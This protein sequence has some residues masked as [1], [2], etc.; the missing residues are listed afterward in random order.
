MKRLV[1]A[2]MFATSALL[3]ME[4]PAQLVSIAESFLQAKPILALTDTVVTYPHYKNKS[5]LF[6]QERLAAFAYIIELKNRATS[7]EARKTHASLLLRLH[8]SLDH[9]SP[10][11]PQ[12]SQ[13]DLLVIQAQTLHRIF[14]SKKIDSNNPT[15]T[16][17]QTKDGSI[18]IQYET[19]KAQE[20][21]I[22]A[23]QTRAEFIRHFSFEWTTS[24]MLND[25]AQ[26]DMDNTST[27]TG[28]EFLF[29]QLDTLAKDFFNFGQ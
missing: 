26:K 18:S 8:A 22:Q 27:Q 14:K 29:S 6:T 10:Y 24:E 12:I 7:S 21:R 2:A 1:I 3:A 5:E 4:T 17:T 11:L 28:L 15:H 13:E 16:C 23:Q 9:K 20:L 25:A 19:L